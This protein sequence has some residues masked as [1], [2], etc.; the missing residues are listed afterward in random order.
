MHAISSVPSFMI[1]GVILAPKQASVACSLVFVLVKGG[2]V[3][4]PSKFYPHIH[5][6]EV[7]RHCNN[8]ALLTFFM[9]KCS[10][11]E[12]QPWDTCVPPDILSG[13]YLFQQTFS[14]WLNKKNVCVNVCWDN[15]VP[16][17]M[18]TGTTASQLKSILG[19]ICP[20][21]FL[22]FQATILIHNDRYQF[23][24]VFRAQQFHNLCNGSIF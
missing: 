24:D 12:I 21:T 20:I 5:I 22:L 11:H 16:A 19:Q 4:V 23:T 13:I 2:R 7:S 6:V 8:V 1:P 14:Y 15:G 18:S 10:S 17:K 3:H 9:Q